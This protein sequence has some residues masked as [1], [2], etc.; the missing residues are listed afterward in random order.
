MFPHRDHVHT[1]MYAH[2]RADY[3]DADPVPASLALDHPFSGLGVVIGTAADG[4]REGFDRWSERSCCPS[5]RARVHPS[6]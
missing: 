1:L 4:D 3:R 5:C 6:R 2:D